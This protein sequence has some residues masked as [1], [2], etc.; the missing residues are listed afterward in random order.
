MRQMQF[1][2]FECMR[3][4]SQPDGAIQTNEL[5]LGG[6]HGVTNTAGS[7][8]FTQDIK[9]KEGNGE[10]SVRSVSLDGEMLAIESKTKSIF[11]KRLVISTIG[12]PVLFVSPVSVAVPGRVAEITFTF[13]DSLHRD[14]FAYKL[15]LHSKGDPRV[16][17][18][19]SASE[20]RS[21]TT[22]SVL[23][24]LESVGVKSESVVSR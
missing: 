14:L 24:A 22:L 20:S 10:E 5:T 21:S 17:S 7:Q 15:F 2:Y 13:S 12:L 6:T 8:S 23:S 4:S 18:S 9:V 16:G 3:L 1:A 11:S 19:F